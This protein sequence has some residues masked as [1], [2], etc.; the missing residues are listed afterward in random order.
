MSEREP[1]PE[2]ELGDE[3]MSRMVEQLCESKAEEFRLLGYDQV[4]GA[5]V[6]ECVSDKYHKK[7]TPPLHVV[8]NDILSLK[9]TQYMNF[10]TLSLYRGERR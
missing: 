7:G 8:V 2:P 5:D 6:W 10:I 9:V 4:K 1:V 3:E